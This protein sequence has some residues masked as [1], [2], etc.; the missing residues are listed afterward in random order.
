MG[1][2][3]VNVST[4]R[5]KPVISADLIVPSNPPKRGRPKKKF[6]TFEGNA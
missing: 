2:K 1:E 6:V 4:A 3:L 5:L